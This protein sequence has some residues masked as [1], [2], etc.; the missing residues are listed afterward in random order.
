METVKP[1]S[2]FDATV[3]ALQSEITTGRWPVGSRIPS[4]ATL[5]ARLGVSRASLREAVRSLS[6]LGLLRS[7]QG[8]GTYVV[9]DNAADVALRN[10]LSTALPDDVLQVRWGLEMVAVKLAAAYRTSEDLDIMQ[11]AL[12]ARAESAASGD[13]NAFTAADI[14]FHSAV[15]DASH[16][17]V[18]ADLYASF[19]RT[20]EEVVSDGHC[21]DTS[22]GGR[23]PH[24]EQILDAIRARDP[25]AATTATEML[26]TINNRP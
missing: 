26:L 18:L 10:H 16:N 7:K 3:Q 1:V 8:D 19:T 6:H 25:A 5:T 22:L 23:D 9:S 17:T 4:E 12:H 20:L 24:H 13:K 14:A 2:T 15:A 21:L 11:L